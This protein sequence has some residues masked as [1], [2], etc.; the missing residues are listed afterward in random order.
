MIRAVDHINL[1]VSDLDRSVK[2]YTELL[3]FREFRRAHLKGEWIESII[4]LKD[5]SA[6]VA[7]VI[8]LEGEPRLE[9]RHSMA[10]RPSRR[11]LAAVP[12]Y[13]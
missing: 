9:G 12:A 7:Y 8:A 13:R 5:V 11:I 2:F 3:G 4:G 1:V 10:C 6:D